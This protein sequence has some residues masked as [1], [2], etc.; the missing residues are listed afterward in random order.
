MANKI[1][2][3]G[4]AGYIGSHTV[5]QLGES[6][7]NVVVYD[8]LSTGSAAAL[9]CGELIVGDLGDT[10][11]LYQTFAQHQFDAVL[12]FAAHL[13]V[14]ESILNPLDYYAN[15]TRNT[16][17][18]LR[19]C[20]AFG[21]NKFVFSSTAAVYGEPQENPVRETSAT[22]PINPYGR[23]K[24]MS[25]QML[26][27][28]SRTSALNYVI[29]RYFNVAGAEVAG[30]IGQSSRKAEHLIK[31]ACDAAL[32]RRPGVNIFGTD[33]PTPDGTGIRDY[34]HVEDLAA[35]HI[36]ALRYLEADGQSQ[37]LNCGY[38]QGYS[39][40]QVLEKMKGISGVDFAVFATERRAGDP[41]CVIAS[42]DRIRQIL[43]WQPKYNDLDVIVS[44]AFA[45]E[46]RLAQIS[47]LQQISTEKVE[48]PKLHFQHELQ[49]Q[50]V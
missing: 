31:V 22:A 1:L 49:V 36:D 10:E 45:W 21:V 13:S 20:Q 30:R 19:C 18:L 8:N 2:V 50:P 25:E 4:G 24:L 40:R 28:Y 14:P 7:Y 15:N 35:A 37:I 9:L 11:R 32:G 6:G 16:L 47:L 23:S 3:T 17:N 34:I 27:D 26:Q 44:T 5:R 41:A 46:K 38:G 48:V 42:S 29:L 12:H 33:F 39:V 43:G